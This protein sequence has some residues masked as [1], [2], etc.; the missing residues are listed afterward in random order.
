MSINFFPRRR[1]GGSAPSFLV[2][3]VR[4]FPRIPDPPPLVS[5]LAEREKKEWVSHRGASAACRPGLEKFLRLPVT[6]RVYD[7]CWGS[8][9][10]FSGLVSCCIEQITQ[11]VLDHHKPIGG[12]RRRIPRSHCQTAP[13]RSSDG[14]MGTKTPLPRYMALFAPPRAGRREG[15]GRGRRDGVEEA[16]RGASF[17]RNRSILKTVIPSIL[18]FLQALYCP[19]HIT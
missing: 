17:R 14:T 12:R 3:V 4:L 13:R 7:T 5:R 9:Y 19:M 10:K 1:E 15:A 8:I 18:R 2:V 6:Q 11:P 16:G